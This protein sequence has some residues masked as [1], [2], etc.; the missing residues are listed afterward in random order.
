MSGVWLHDPR[1]ATLL[2]EQAHRMRLCGALCDV[3]VSVEGQEFPV[4]G[5]V[6]ACASRT[7]AALL[8]S[9]SV[10]YSLDFLAGRTFRRILE[11]SYT[12]RLEAPAEELG[13]L[14][15]AAG[16]LAMEGLEQQIAEVA[17][18][19]GLGGEGRG[20]EASEGAGQG[21]PEREGRGG[22]AGEGR[23]GPAGEG[24]GGLAGEGRGGP[25]GE[26][27]GGPKE[28]GRGGHE[29]EGQGG[30]EGEGRGG[31]EGAGRGGP[32]GAGRG[33]PEGAGRG[34]PEGAGRGGPEGEG[35]GGSK[36]VGRGVAG[37]GLTPEERAELWE[38]PA[39]RPPEAGGSPGGAGTPLRPPGA[40]VR[41]TVI[42]APCRP[43]PGPEGRGGVS[44]HGD[45][46]QDKAQAQA[47]IRPS[48]AGPLRAAPAVRPPHRLAFPATVDFGPYPGLGLQGSARPQLPGRIEEAGRRPT[49]AFSARATGGHPGP[50]EESAQPPQRL[51]LT[52]NSFPCELC[53][54]RFPDNLRLRMH[55]QSHSG[56]SV[57]MCNPCGVRIN[58][59]E[60]PMIHRQAHSGDVPVPLYLLCGKRYESRFALREHMAYH[61][62]S[63][64]YCCWECQRLF[65]SVSA[66]KRHLRSHAGRP[67]HQCQFCRHRFQ[68]ENA[69]RN[70]KQIHQGEKPYQCNDCKK[71]FSL[72]HQLETHYRVHTGEKPFECKLCRQRSRDYS[73][74]I[75][76]LRTHNGALPYQCTVC[77]EFC[78]SLSAM[79]KHI[80]SHKPEEIP[81]D[82][83]LEET[84]LYLCYV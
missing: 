40:P 53:G 38:A 74:M 11:Y 15:E 5:L 78:S 68:D 77:R 65:P 6:L 10:R 30:D 9:G 83:S 34:G 28:D 14:L 50:A 60:E 36:G 49:P 1:H 79:Q 27:R 29:G 24:R 73:A 52:M 84:Y 37:S 46:A 35:Q 7:F 26:G 3:V 61:G 8:R 39:P 81:S 19:R 13:E 64:S 67:L 57:V 2:L 56:C 20:G 23:G 16:I 12:G 41:G 4:H 71:K 63:W 62:G 48:A 47:P 75:K 70:H 32:E 45:Q 42:T 25:A 31:P 58:T 44:W 66:L 33:G 51:M 80:K 18:R 72:K 82:W 17:S 43:A 69:L 54:K 76:H 59:E 55:L 21:G 22:P